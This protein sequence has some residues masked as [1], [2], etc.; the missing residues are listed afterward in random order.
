MSQNSLAAYSR[1]CDH[2]HMI[3]PFDNKQIGTLH[4]PPRLV[5]SQSKNYEC[6][7]Y[8]LRNRL[9]TPWLKRYHWVSQDVEFWCQFWFWPRSFRVSHLNLNFASKFAPWIA[10][11]SNVLCWINPFCIMLKCDKL[12]IGKTWDDV[13]SC[14]SGSNRK[15]MD[16]WT[17]VAVSI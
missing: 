17:P 11:L 4:S 9:V 12:N 2:F 7:A 15:E 13:V 3:L 5:Q 10:I 1:P 6:I 14:L 16:C 8:N